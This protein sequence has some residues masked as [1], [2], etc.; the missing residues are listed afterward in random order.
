MRRRWL[1][2]DLH[3]V[4]TGPEVLAPNWYLGSRPGELAPINYW[5]QLITGNYQQQAFAATRAK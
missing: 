3:T 2:G 1:L 5:D 4:R